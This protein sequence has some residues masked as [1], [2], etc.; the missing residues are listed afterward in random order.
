MFKKLRFG[1]A[2]FSSRFKVRAAS[3]AN[4]AGV[5]R[6]SAHAQMPA[7]AALPDDLLFPHKHASLPHIRE[8]MT[9]MLLMPFLNAPDRAEPKRKLD[10]PLLLRLA[11]I[12]LIRVYPCKRLSLSGGKKIFGGAPTPAECLKP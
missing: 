10:L 7:T 4:R 8:Q 3:A 1:A 5:G 11:R 2:F 12:A 6:S 9:K